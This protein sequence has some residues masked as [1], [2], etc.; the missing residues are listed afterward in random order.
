MQLLDRHIGQAVTRLHELSKSVAG[1]FV[2]QIRFAAALLGF[3]QIGIILDETVA[4][5][6]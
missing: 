5:L 6:Q 3:E 4:N 1:Q 2:T